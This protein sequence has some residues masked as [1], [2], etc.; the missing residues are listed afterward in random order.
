MNGITKG[1]RT[2]LKSVV[3]QQFKVLRTEVE[4]R[5]AEM[6]AGITEAVRDK[7]SDEDGHRAAVTDR[8]AE[9]VRAAER[10]ITDY[11]IAQAPD[12]GVTI[13]QPVSLSLPRINWPQDDRHGDRQS[14]TKQ[15]DASVKAALLRLDRQ[16]A[17]L[18]RT[19][20]VD[21]IESEDALRFLSNIPTVGELVPADRLAEIMAGD[22]DA[23]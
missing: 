6:A 20:A 23:A 7:Y 14:A 3:R 13:N 5:R 15:L 2:E 21:A 9:I 22:E 10:E 17:D 11:M 18:L 4:Q 19:L 1:E 8:I 12:C 16:E